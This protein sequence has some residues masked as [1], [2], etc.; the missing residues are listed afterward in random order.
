M[1]GEE[2]R[3]FSRIFFNVRAR[4]EVGSRSF[5]LS[6]IANLSVGGCLVELD[7]PDAELRPGLECVFKILL[8]RM[9]PPVEIK[10]EIVRVEDGELGLKFVAIDPENL[11]HL[12]NIIRYN[13]SDPDK[14]EQELAA[15]PGLK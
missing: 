11:F 13:S 1:A 6:R 9:A 5:E 7:A 15:H 10:G 8:D 3:R 12:Q 14:I 4:L 2:K